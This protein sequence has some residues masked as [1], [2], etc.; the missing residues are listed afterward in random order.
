MITIT[1]IHSYRQQY[2]QTENKIITPREGHG[3]SL[4]LAGKQNIWTK[5]WK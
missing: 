3:D 1:L 4:A 5:E 2:K